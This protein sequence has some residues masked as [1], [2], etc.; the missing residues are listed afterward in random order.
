MNTIT[1]LDIL[2]KFISNAKVS[3]DG[4]EYDYL[5]DFKHVKYHVIWSDNG[6]GDVFDVYRI[7]EVQDSMSGPGYDVETII[8]HEGFL[9]DVINSINKD[10]E[11]LFL[12]Y[13]KCSDWK[14]YLNNNT[15]VLKN[16]A[17]KL[18]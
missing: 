1:N 16:N 10:Y 5:V 2:Q 7:D 14:R 4:Q 8:L 13:D 3:F 9:I 17:N 12:I 6:K 18:V 15:K 11:E